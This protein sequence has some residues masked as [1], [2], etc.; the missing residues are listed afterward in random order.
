MY[1]VFVEILKRLDDPTEKVRHCALR[2]L[3]EVFAEPPEAFKEPNFR[4]HHELIIDTLLTH[5]DDD[6]KSVRDLVFGMFY[7]ET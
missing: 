5:F 2:V 6:D 1:I 4:A 3:P 7:M